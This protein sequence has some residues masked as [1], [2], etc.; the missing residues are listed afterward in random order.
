MSRW[1]APGATFP[2]DGEL[3]TLV[4]CIPRRQPPF[5]PAGLARCD[6][7]TLERWRR[8]RY[9]YAP[10]QFAQQ[11]MVQEESGFL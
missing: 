2:Q 6:E 9:C 5:K 4:R 10:H 8:A 3:P 7:A 1:L 11:Y